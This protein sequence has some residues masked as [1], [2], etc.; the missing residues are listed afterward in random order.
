MAKQHTQLTHFIMSDAY[1]WSTLSVPGRWGCGYS[2]LLWPC[3]RAF[4]WFHYWWER[5]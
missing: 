4:P 3:S 1:F 5:W 2:D